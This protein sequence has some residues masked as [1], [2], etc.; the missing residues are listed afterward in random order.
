M[1]TDPDPTSPAS[2]L[3]GSAALPGPAPVEAL[4]EAD[5]RA[6]HAALAYVRVKDRREDAA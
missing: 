4:S 5:A 3:A 6:E 1:N 2:V